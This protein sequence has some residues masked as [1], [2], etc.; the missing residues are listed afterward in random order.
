MIA[1]LSK[2]DG[3]IVAGQIGYIIQY[4]TKT[5]ERLEKVNKMNDGFTSSRT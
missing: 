1:V 2:R 5:I 3:F 4:F